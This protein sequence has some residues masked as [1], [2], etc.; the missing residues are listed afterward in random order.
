MTSD[1]NDAGAPVSPAVAVALAAGFGLLAG[2]GELAFAAAR[3]YLRHL[4]VFQPPDLL[5]MAPA[6]GAVVFAGLTAAL[7]GIGA[8]AGRRPTQPH[9]VGLGTGLAA[10][11]LLLLLPPIHPAASLLLAIGLGVRVSSVGAARDPR[12]PRLARRIVVG[13]VPAL[14]ATAVLV[15]ALPAVAERRA[16]AGLPPPSAMAPNVLLIILDTVRALSLS[17]YGY[18]RPTTPALKRWAS[19][20]ARFTAAQS[21]A[22]WTLPSH[23]SLF[24]GHEAHDLST[25]WYT[26]LDDRTPTLAEHLAARGYLTAGFT[27]NLPYTSREVGLAR[28]FQHY[29]D[30]PLSLG[31][32]L[33]SSSLVRAVTTSD[34]IRD[35]VGTRELLVRKRAPDINR[36]FFAWLDRPRSRPFFAFLNYYDAHTPFVPPEPFRS[37]FAPSGAPFFSDLPRRETDT[38]W[39][40]TL[41]R[42]AMN[43]YDGAISYL[44]S[45]LDSLLTGLEQRGLLEQTIVVV[46]SDHGEEFAE[47]GLFSHGNSLYLP[48]LQV[49]L[50][51]LFPGGVPAGIEV[52]T[53]VS[54]RDLPATIVDLVGSLGR[55]PFPGRSLR[56]FWEDSAPSGEVLYAEV[57][58]APKL[59][60]WYPSTRGDLL[61]VQEGTVRFIKNSDGTEEVYD[62]AV[63]PL[64]QRN[65]VSEAKLL[66][67]VGRLRALV[68]SA[69]LAGSAARRR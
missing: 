58:R 48:S 69:R 49:P 60:S 62:I 12:L 1:R 40:S 6:A 51:L 59:P 14:A 18:D 35:L 16:I 53:P 3:K 52:A 5:W 23:A 66:D 2:L 65:L 26:P 8:A 54:T 31:A 46:T 50:L 24:T 11:G 33:T 4:F 47:H 22:P 41:I 28:G 20:G 25:D 68:D 7:L 15:R 38:P 63:D 29:E 45:R 56:R 55:A 39:D 57:R 10:F 42:G 19:R 17:L 37:E 44:D 21:T 32:F 34:W 9:I 64:E 27:A 30:W 67:R 43:A 36:D 61:S 13:S